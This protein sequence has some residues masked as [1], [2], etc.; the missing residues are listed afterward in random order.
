M[1]PFALETGGTVFVN[2]GFVPQNLSATYAAD[3]AAPAGTVTLS[4][5]AM[6]PEEAGPFTPG[7]DAGKRIEW[8]RNVDRLARLA[9]G[10]LKPFAPVY[11]DA[12]AGPAGALPQGGETTIDFPNNH[13]GYAITWFGFAILTPIMLV[14]WIWRQG[15]RRSA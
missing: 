12:P 4:G 10:A 3:N 2:R 8:V 13:L 14:V 15:R 1:T 9:D 5:I 11:V 7:P 6:P